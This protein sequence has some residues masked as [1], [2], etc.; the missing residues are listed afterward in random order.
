[1]Q[2]I[3]FPEYFFLV[4]IIMSGCS[5][6]Q[7]NPFNPDQSIGG[8][9]MQ[10]DYAKKFRIINHDDYKH[11]QVFTPWPGSTDTFNYILTRDMVVAEKY[12]TSENT[13]VITL[14]LTHIVCFSTTHLPFLELLNEIDKI[15]GFPTTDYI[16]SRKV[17]ERVDR[18]FIKD[19][20][21]ANEINFETLL[22]LNPDVIFA[23][24]MGNEQSMLDKIRLSGL[25]IVLNADY[26]ERHPLGRAEWIRFFGCF[27]GKT[28]EADSI[29]TYIKNSYHDTR[30]LTE[31]AEII[32]T[33][34]TGIV[35]GDTWFM[36]GGNHYGSIFFQDAGSDY[37][38]SDNPSREI[39]H[40]SFE[41]V[42]QK[43]GDADFWVGTASY[44]SL[45]EIAGADARYTKFKAFK[46]GKVYNYTAKL[47][48]EG[49]NAYFEM[50]YARPD[51]ILKDLVKI[52]HPEIV[53]DHRFYFYKKLY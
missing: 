48:P 36:P 15:T 24:S 5:G 18:G 41:S 32:P 17:R 8:D 30:K 46:T 1:M 19:L 51:I 40:L 11:L 28:K 53:P 34:F 44:N 3:K 42:Y 22:A 7:K 50:G 31:N 43:A 14:P 29:F 2:K 52:F 26:L 25:K 9:T 21:P 38:W 33:V 39:L 13:T 27:F 12:K 16:T 45:D 47:G 23:F 6:N 4:V 35:Y 49:G 37:L 10:L 20:G